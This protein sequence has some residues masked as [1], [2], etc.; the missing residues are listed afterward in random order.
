MIYSGDFFTVTARSE[1]RGML[2]SVVVKG[3]Q[4]PYASGNERFIQTIAH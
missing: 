3:Q 2:V 1:V 4:P